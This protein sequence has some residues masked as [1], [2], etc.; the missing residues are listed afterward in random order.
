[1]KNSPHQLNHRKKKAIREAGKD[2]KAYEKEAGEI[3][4]KQKKLYLAS[5]HTLKIS[6]AKARSK[7]KHHTSSFS[8]DEGKIN[9]ESLHQEGEHWM[10]AIQKKTLNTAN[11]LQKKL[12]KLTLFGRKK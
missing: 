11:R 10:R 1:M 9:P 6:K 7:H 2:E 3:S 12:Q 5:P 8:E 4:K